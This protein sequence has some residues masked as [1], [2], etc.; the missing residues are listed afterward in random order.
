MIGPELEAII[1]NQRS[2]REFLQ[3][4]A[5]SVAAGSLSRSV[6]LAATRK[7]KMCLNTGN[8]GVKA[9]LAE[10]IALA[11]K[12]GFE[13]VDPNV[14]ELAALSD[15]AMGQLL[16]EL[17]SKKLELGSAG[18]SVPVGQPDE[19]FSEFIK[20]LAGTA[21]TLERARVRR[22]VT[23]ISPSDNRLTYL[24]NFR[25]HARRMREVATVLGDHGISFGL[26][27]VGPKT[28]WT[29]GKYPFIHTMESMKELIAEIGKPNLGFLLDS[30]H[31]HNAG[32]GAADVLTLKNSDIVAVHLNDAPAG[33]PVDQLVD[34]HRE[35]PAETGVIDVGAFL[36]ALN[37]VGY[38]GPAA[39]EPIN[40]DLR[41]L[42]PDEIM[43]KTAAA[44]KKAFAL[45]K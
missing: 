14:K 27:Y 10:S 37:Q 38:D 19:K 45:I 32:E 16:D 23:W 4:A 2:R 20:D 12:Y 8:V 28:S 35:L 9:N 5:G 41:K 24:Q 30:W 22:F 33:V 25:L 34:N 43:T 17:R 7:M 36:N 13:A 15:S 21:K 29:R 18:Q 3:S 40:A 6:S 11:A 31:W 1:V 42:P 26:E 44:M 39:A